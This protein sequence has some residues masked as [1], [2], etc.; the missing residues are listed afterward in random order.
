MAADLDALFGDGA[1]LG[2]GVVAKAQLRFRVHPPRH[3]A[4]RDVLDRVVAAYDERLAMIDEE[5]AGV[6]KR[7]GRPHDREAGPLVLALGLP[8][9]AKA[10]PRAPF[11][12]GSR[13]G[14]W[15]RDA[16]G[17]IRYG[18]P[19]EGR[20]MGNS[21]AAPA[22]P[23]EPE[24]GHLRSGS[25][26]G[27]FGNDHAL[28]EFLL[29]HGGGHGFT[30][31][32]LRFLG[33]WY[34][35]G[36]DGG[37]LFD[38]F[39]ECAGLTRDEL[40]GGTANFRFG[41]QG[42]TYEEA[43]FEFFAAQQQL[44]M[45]DASEGDD[46][47]SD[48]EGDEEWDRV[49]NDEIK[50]LLDGVF[51]KYEELKAD[52]DLQRQFAGE[53]E[54]QRRRFFNAARRSEDDTSGVADSVAGDW[55][56]ARQVDVALEGMRAL[57]LFARPARAARAAYVHGRPHLRDAVSMDGRLLGDGPDNPLLAGKDELASLSASQLML[58]YAAAELHRR[59]DP[60]A[61]QFSTEKQSEAGS[62]D[63]GDAALAAIA[64]KTAQWAE[65]SDVVRDHV[66]E[67]VDFLVAELN[68]VNS[69][70]GTPVK[71]EPATKPRSR[72]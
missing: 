34:G 15:Y 68:R 53:P 9:V 62:G 30:E 66:D 48:D 45:G 35:T 50:P 49:L 24:L 55:D 64:S 39:L 69:R 54:R 10:V 16:K 70:E 40:K 27:V 46:A 72:R 6:V 25:F 58:L 60:H 31:G 13:G 38:A 28:T 37:A 65:A 21:G 63:L 22:G 8:E 3:L 19:P 47:G 12:P 42:L 5:I 14:K 29:E 18:D 1:D 61:R 67:L 71:H 2:Q 11:R 32:E 57:G 26:L 4:A 59:W 23:P 44:F 51:I 36:E 33:A 7:A 43:V 17:N 41:S 56:P 52:E 20:F